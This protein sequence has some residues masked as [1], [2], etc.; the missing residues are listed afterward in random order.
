MSK[1]K[2]PRTFTEEVWTKLEE[3]PEWKS[4][5]GL[6]STSYSM[7][8]SFDE[9]THDAIKNYLFGIREDIGPFA[10]YGNSVGRYLESRG[11]EIDTDWLSEDDVDYLATQLYKDE[12][13]EFERPIV[14]P[15]EIGSDTVIFYGFIDLYSPSGPSQVLD[16][17]TGNI[18]RAA[19]KYKSEEYQQTRLYS[20][21]LEL[22][23]ITTEYC[24]VKLFGRKGD[25]DVQWGPLRLTGE[26]KD[27]PT[28]Y[29]KAETEKYINDKVIPQIKA[30]SDMYKSYL[31]MF[32][33]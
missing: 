7:L 29:N 9:Y 25:G 26:S 17:K 21:G 6:P 16:F 23:G 10:P 27:I 15:I 3:R 30:I 28:P 12:K 22:E 19:K 32:G 18:D 33:E 4:Y 2:L 24:G 14:I 13:Y 20:Y 31:K 1:I 8:T 5:I 11:T